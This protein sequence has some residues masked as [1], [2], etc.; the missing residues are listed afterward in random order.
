[1]EQAKKVLS[2]KS[3]TIPGYDVE[4]EL[5]IIS[6]TIERQREFSREQKLN[7]KF[8]IFKGLNGKRFLIGSWPKVWRTSCIT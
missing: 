8:A 5:G 6:A 4:V 1:M 2:N 3:K 7:G